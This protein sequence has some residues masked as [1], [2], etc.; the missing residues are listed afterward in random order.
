M[1]SFFTDNGIS[2]GFAGSQYNDKSEVKTE[3]EKIFKHH[4][5]AKY[6]WKVKEIRFLHS[7][8]AI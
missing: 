7:E 8:V 2:I 3:I 6:V 4:Q 5:V 1:V